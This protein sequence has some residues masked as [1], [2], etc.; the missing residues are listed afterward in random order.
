MLHGMFKQINF[1]QWNQPRSN[2]LFSDPQT[3]ALHHGLCYYIR[4]ITP[5]TAVSFLF[6]LQLKRQRVKSFLIHPTA[7]SSFSI[8]FFAEVTRIR[9][10][11]QPTSRVLLSSHLKM[12][13]CFLTCRCMILVL[14]VVSLEVSVFRDPLRRPTKYNFKSSTENL[15]DRFSCFIIQAK[16][17]W[18]RHR[19]WGSC[20]GRKKVDVDSEPILGFWCL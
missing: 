1:S 4:I 2:G 9:S 3:D 17:A 12:C 14:V 18:E 19:R 6:P 8:P 5:W 10:E 13:W 15:D 7:H 11:L 20:P 16:P